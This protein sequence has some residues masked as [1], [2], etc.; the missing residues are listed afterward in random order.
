[1]QAKGFTSLILPFYRPRGQ[2]GWWIGRG[3]GRLAGFDRVF[4]E[5]ADFGIGAIGLTLPLRGL[6]GD[7]GMFSIVFSAPDA[8]SDLLRTDALSALQQRAALFH[9]DDHAGNRYGMS[10][11]CKT[12]ACRRASVKSC[13]GSLRASHKV[14]L[15]R[16]WPFPPAR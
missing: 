13:N 2:W 4:R 7:R 15:P 10:E 5:A 12:P 1:M 3:C 14:T 6:F 9:D 16:S 11:W 8:Q